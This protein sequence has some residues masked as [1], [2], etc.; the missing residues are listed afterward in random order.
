MAVDG[1]LVFKTKIDSDGFTKGTKELSSK[2]IELQN[3]IAAAESEVKN[4]RAELEALGN[5]KVKPK[6][7]E[8]L[9]AD[10]DKAQSKLNQLDRRADE[11]I[12]KKRSDFGISYND[13]ATLQDFLNKD[14]QWKKLQSEITATEEKL[15]SYKARLA[16]VNRSAPMGSETAEYAQKQA[17]LE[18]LTGQIDVYKAKLRE[19]EQAEHSAGSSAQSSAERLKTVKTWLD[20]T[21]SG[22]KKLGSLAKAA[23]SRLKSAFSTTLS[24]SVKKIGSQF[25]TLNSKTNILDKSLKRIKGRLT[26]MFF[27]RLV[28]VPLNAIKDGLGEI[29]KI[30]PAFNKNLSAIASSFNFLKSS[31]AAAA[32]PIV[33]ALTPA[34]TTLFNTI[35]NGLNTVGEFVSLISGKNIYSQ[36][37]KNQTDYAKSLDASTDS[38]NKN[39]KAT[40]KNQHALAS[41]DEINT[42]DKTSTSDSTAATA[43]VADFKNVTAG[44][45]SLAKTLADF[46]KKSDFSGLGKAIG[47][48]INSSLKKINWSAI[49]ATLKKWANNIADLLNGFIAKV[50]WRLVGKTIGHG[51]HSAIVFAQTFLT[52]FNWKKF[53]TS[54]AQLINGGVNTIGWTDIGKTIA[55]GF[56]AVF[57]S[58]YGFVSTLE[59][60]RIGQSIHSSI[61]NVIQ[62][63]DWN[64]AI[65][66]LSLGI[67]GFVKT[68]IEIVGDPNFTQLG[69]NIAESLKLLINNIDWTS[70]SNLFSTLLVGALDLTNGFIISVNW[71]DFG[72]QLA[73]SFNSYFGEG[74]GGKKFLEKVGTTIGNI[75]TGLLDVII[76][77]FEDEETSNTFSKGVESFLT[78]IPWR[79]L[80]VKAITGGVSAAGWLT[81]TATDLVDDF[82]KGLTNG[83]EDASDDE[84][85]NKAIKNLGKSIMNLLI[86]VLNSAITVITTTIPNAFV[87]LLKLILYGLNAVMWVFMG[88]DFYNQTKNNL[89]AWEGYKDNWLVPK[90][91]H[92]ATGTVV[93]A[94]YGEF[95]AVLGDN[96]REAEVVSPVSKIE[97]AVENV[98]ARRGLLT[99]DSN[100]TIH[101]TFVLE[102]GAVLFDVVGNEDDKYRARH[103]ASRF[104]GG[105][106]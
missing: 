68:A 44:K 36:A 73:A 11:I 47:E 77:F 72:K 71:G 67:N 8:G 64:L 3:K 2:T 27:A 23:G 28:T 93:P 76:G 33:S 41:F 86:D 97:E 26:R 70:I 19:A 25:S 94:N 24:S 84:E 82:A 13:D 5:A 96:R 37:V 78:S 29:A 22:L 43:A 85:L 60:G 6:V 58:A 106:A 63:T 45:N 79:E 98:L 87:G 1:N 31:F 7:A 56:N 90:I 20:R 30:N 46:F 12:N 48:K 66:T 88:D 92:L 50:D 69:A 89:D 35:A 38:T 54:F 105:T 4:L 100:R 17:K 16:E 81:Q 83:F 40:Q 39:T 21:I 61:S 65:T 99:D 32:A 102:N 18:Q 59:W 74:G 53:G 49:K 57:E 95:L 42:M 14:S 9:E 91:P 75:C 15:Q 55:A 103:G 101:A 10:I 51:I 104:A 80:F 34:I 52:R 62:N